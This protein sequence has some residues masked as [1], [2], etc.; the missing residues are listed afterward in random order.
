M[1]GGGDEIRGRRLVFGRIFPWDAVREVEKIGI[2]H[3]G[4]GL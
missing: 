3:S 2:S 1:E 4:L